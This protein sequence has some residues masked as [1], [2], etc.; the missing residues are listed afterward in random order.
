MSVHI[1]GF[2]PEVILGIATVSVAFSNPAFLFA[3]ACLFVCV[4]VSGVWCVW[5][6]WCVC[7]DLWRCSYACVGM[8]VH[9]HTDAA[10][11]SGRHARSIPAFDPGIAADSAADRACHVHTCLAWHVFESRAPLVMCACLYSHVFVRASVH[12][13]SAA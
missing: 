2:M 7:W 6:V 1:A 10:W 9:R 3:R 5:C 8:L 11:H 12:V 13:C 4:C